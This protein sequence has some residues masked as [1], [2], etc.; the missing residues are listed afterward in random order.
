M[1]ALTFF[2]S[3]KEKLAEGVHQLGTHQLRVALVN[4]ASGVNQSDDNVLAD[5]TEIA[6]TNLLNNPTSRNLTTSSSEMDGT[7]YR[8][9]LADLTLEAS[10][11]SLQ[12]FRY[13]VIYNDTATGDPLIG[14]VD[15]G[16]DLTLGEGE[17][18]LIDF[19]ATTGALSLTTA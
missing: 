2:H 3:F 7:T 14:Y 19:N 4:A 8:L 15:Y 17:Q 9:K 12:A 11:G 5:L 10:G 1:P 18:L 6:Y 13:V 16:A